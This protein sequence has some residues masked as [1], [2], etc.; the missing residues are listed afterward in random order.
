MPF[1]TKVQP[2]ESK[3]SSA[4]NDPAK[5]TTSGGSK[6]RLK[7]LFERQF[8]SVLRIASSE[9]LAVTGE[10]RVGDR[11]DGGGGDQEPTSVCL[12]RMVL[13][14]M[15]DSNDKSSAA[16][17]A[18]CSRNRCNCFNGN[19]DDSSD[20]EID[21]DAVMIAAG[22]TSDDSEILK[23]L[24]PCASIRERNLLADV[25]KIVEKI[26]TGKGRAD[27]WKIAADGLRSLGYDA[28]VC[29]SLWEKTPMIPAA[30]YV[31][32]AGE[33]EYVDVI[34]D[35]QRFLL[36]VDFRSEFE[37]ARS[38]KNYRELLQL[39]PPIFVGKADRLEQIVSVVSEAARQSLK[40]KGLHFPPW[41]KT[42]YMRAK[43][44]SPYH[45]A[46]TTSSDGD[47]A[48]ISRSRKGEGV[49]SA[50]LCPISPVNYFTAGEFKVR[51]GDGG[52]STGGEAQGK[53]TAVLSPWQPPVVKTKASAPAKGAMVVAGLASVLG[54]NPA[55]PNF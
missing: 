1:Q 17:A 29:K 50:A 55:S 19:C 49:D 20:D 18:R 12:D 48:T 47:C 24:V 53:S 31:R 41:R 30:R 33:Y 3:G 15:E 16:A 42:E 45:R 14:F 26:K 37:I 34:I 54:E 27:S 36:D 32:R 2:A 22:H 5:S 43:W 23:G 46:F 7:R 52:V 9:K 38:T 10:G 39:L 51:L 6:S 25:S 11:D 8:P 35:G 13:S 4:R 44:L 21:G 28:S 40:K